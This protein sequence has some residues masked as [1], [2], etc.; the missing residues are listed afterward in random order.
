VERNS[1]HLPYPVRIEA[2]RGG[3][4]RFGDLSHRGAL[5]CLP[6]GMW[7]SPV[8]AASEIDAVALGLVF[9]TVPPIELCLI[10]AGAAPWLTPPALR[11]LSREAGFSIDGMTTASAVHIYN[12]MIEEQRRVAALLIPLD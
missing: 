2:Y 12:L 8:K 7:A 10:G 11:A 6:D 4:F 1:P 9:A 3:G 5:L